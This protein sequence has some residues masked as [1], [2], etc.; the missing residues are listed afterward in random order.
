MAKKHYTEREDGNRQ[1]VQGIGPPHQPLREEKRDRVRHAQGL[2]LCQEE[3]LRHREGY[4]AE[5]EAEVRRVRGNVRDGPRNP[6]ISTKTGF[7][8]QA[9]NGP[10]NTPGVNQRRSPGTVFC[11][12]VFPPFGTEIM[13]VP[14]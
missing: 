10:F 4:T 1:E 14:V 2:G 7:D 13:A 5:C 6:L 8:R 9:Q 12:V 3:V 11:H